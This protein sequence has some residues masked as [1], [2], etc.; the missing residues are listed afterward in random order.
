MG[1][2]SRIITVVVIASSIIS[3]FLCFYITEQVRKLELTSLR[4]KIDKAAYVMRLVN[5]R[6]LYNVDLETLKVN[7]ETFFD[8]ENMKS[9]AILESDIDIDIHLQREFDPG[10]MDIHKNFY[11]YYN[12]LKLGK[13]AVVYSTSLIEKKLAGFRTKMLWFTFSVILIMTIVLVFLINTLMRPVTKL[14]DV[15]SEIAAGNLDKDIEENGV[16]EVGILSRNFAIMRDAIKDKIEDLAHT[17][18]NLEGEIRQKIL[19]EKKILHQSMVISSVNTFFQRSMVAGSYQKIAELFIPIAQNVIPSTYCF[20]AELNEQKNGMDIL[21]VSRLVQTGCP[22]GEG[23]MTAMGECLRGVRARVLIDKEVVIT[24]DPASHPDFSLL[25]EVH[26]PI[27]NFMGIPLVLGSDVLG[28]VAFADKDKGFFSEDK[29]A[30]QML[31][32][33]LVEA[34]SLKR[35]QD[36]KS[37]LEEMIVQSEKMVS[38]GG[39]AAGMAHEINNP[40][41]GILQNTQVIRNR[42]EKPIPANLKAAEELGIDFSSM[43]AY[44][45]HRGIHKMLDS[46]MDAGKRAAAIVS[47]M[48]SFSRK[49]ASGFVPEDLSLLLDQTLELAASD[50]NLKKKFDFKQIHINREY[51]P[52]LP[53]V[54]CK[55]S[56]IQQVFF[57]IL[58]NGAQAMFGLGEDQHPAFTMRTSME[59]GQVCVEIS[60]NGPG[61]EEEVRKRIFEPFFTTKAVGDGTGLGLAVSYFIITENHKGHIEVES[62]PGRGTTFRV[63][64]PATD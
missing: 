19:K 56:E 4:M 33:A 30:A 6:P 48:L 46:V 34:L 16:G 3:L 41:A 7:M 28:M 44:M 15:A 38:L 12:G 57:N 8:D 45:Q 14:A 64:L 50:Y 40:L 17:N 24:N 43:D 26:F 36:E 35:Q 53:K 25:P 18:E 47:N 60:D 58:S 32:V 27:K 29:D 1:L 21:A 23:D 63:S 5:T 54:K 61:M 31:S 11:I 13:I 10:G 22:A 52:E 20:V 49:S 39:L 37:R 55:S 9:I 62:A 2:R 42:I 51:D 59:K